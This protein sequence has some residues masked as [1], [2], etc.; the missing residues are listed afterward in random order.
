MAKNGFRVLDSDL[1]LMEP[2]DLYERY[3]DPKFRHRAPVSRSKRPGHYADWM[4]DGQSIPPWRAVPEVLRMNESLDRHGEEVMREGWARQF[5]PVS[6]LHAMDAEGVDAAVLFR[7]AG[8]MLVSLDGL[9]PEFALAL[10]R[11]FNDWVADFRKKDPARLKGSAILPQHDPALAAQ[12]ARRAVKELG[13][14]AVVLL[15]MPVAGRHVHDPEFDVLWREVER[16]GVPVCFHGTSGAASKDYLGGRLFGHPSY[17]ALSHASVFPL[18]LMLAVGSMVLGGVLERFPKLRVAFLEGNGSWLPW[19]LYRLDDQWRKFGTAETVKLQARPS[20][21]F[22]R[23]CF[24]SVDAD[25]ELA[26]DIVKRLG[27]GN[28]VFSTDYPHP[29]SAYP[30]AI[31]TFL[32]Q[33]GLS[34]ATKRKILWDNCARLYGL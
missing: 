6:H 16:L 2:P 13:M 3:L 34:P 33:V 5:D 4:V 21:Y 28:I 11:A 20:E 15:P 26:E 22:L 14:A 12:E 24:I 30:H 19:W 29:D 8:S 23:Q 27:D 17:R 9:E 18:E 25:E 10:C 32:A 1:H 31:D 7:T